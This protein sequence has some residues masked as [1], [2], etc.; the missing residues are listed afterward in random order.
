MK[1]PSRIFYVINARV[2]SKRVPNKMLRSFGG[3][4]LIDIALEK[5]K[6]TSIPLD[7]FRLASYDQALL[8]KAEEHGLRYHRRSF[9]SSQEERKLDSLYEWYD[10]YEADFVV[11]IN[12]CLPFL[13]IET[14]DSFVDSYLNSEESGLFAVVKRRNYF[15]DSDFQLITP[16]DGQFMNTKHVQPT[17]E[18]AHV[19]LRKRHSLYWR[20]SVYGRLHSQLSSFVHH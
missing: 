14:I 2:D 12:P 18:A 10:Q 15:W 19:S 11:L 4:T 16:L 8:D 7:Q 1:D 5:I 3:T 6:K 17:Y 20:W 13:S 9:Q